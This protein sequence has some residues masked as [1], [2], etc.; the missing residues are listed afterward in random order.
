MLVSAAAVAVFCTGF[1]I[2]MAIDAFR[3][4]ELGRL[5]R[6]VRLAS[7]LTA[8]SC[9]AVWL[10]VTNP[11]GRPDLDGPTSNSFG[12][13]WACQPL[14]AAVICFREQPTTGAAVHP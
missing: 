1:I 5:W 7:L 6:L 2:L 8:L 14:S 10:A 4:R 3:W 13:G 12:P 11:D 9:L